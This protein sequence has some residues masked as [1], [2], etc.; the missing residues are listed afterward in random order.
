MKLAAM[1]PLQ[2]VALFGAAALAP[3]VI[4]LVVWL[5]FAVSEAVSHVRLLHGFTTINETKPPLR[6]AQVEALMGAPVRIDQSESADQAI[7]GL[8]YHYPAHG[9][10]MRVVFV[11]GVVFRTQIAPETKS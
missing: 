1:S 7:T 8:V 3:L 6:V 11:N 2:K 4:A 5:G 9:E 10:D